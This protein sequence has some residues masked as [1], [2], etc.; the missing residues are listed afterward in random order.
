M[1]SADADRRL[2]LATMLLAWPLAV[3]AIALYSRFRTAPPAL[4]A[5]YASFLTTTLGRT[6]ESVSYTHLTLP[7]ICSV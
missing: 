7:T 2:L 5:E 1:A 3:H 6:A 4:A